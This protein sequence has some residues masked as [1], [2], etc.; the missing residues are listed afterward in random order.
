M[1]GTKDYLVAQVYQRWRQHGFVF[2]VSY[3]A[4]CTDS[5]TLG[6]VVRTQIQ[7]VASQPTTPLAGPT[8]ISWAKQFAGGGDR[9]YQNRRSIGDRDTNFT[10][11]YIY[12]MRPKAKVSMLVPRRRT[13]DKLDQTED[14]YIKLVKTSVVMKEPMRA[15]Q[16]A[17]TQAYRT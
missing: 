7:V 4:D 5:E 10:G 12:Q 3:M 6:H 17:S 8:S 1:N 9:A 13:N 14:V 16:V 15:G 11:F 2:L